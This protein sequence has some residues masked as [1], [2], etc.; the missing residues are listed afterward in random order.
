MN[1]AEL[2]KSF[3]SNISEYFYSMFVNIYKEQSGPNKVVEFKK[4]LKQIK[5]VGFETINKVKQEIVSVVPSYVK[6]VR[7]LFKAHIN[8]I[9]IDRESARK[10]EKA[11]LPEVNVH[12]FIQKLMIEIARSLFNDP[13]LLS[14]C[15]QNKFNKELFHITEKVI[16]EMLPVDDILTV[17][18]DEEDLVFDS[19]VPSRVPGTVKYETGF[20]SKKNIEFESDDNND[21]NND[22]NDDDNYDDNDADDDDVSDEDDN[23]IGNNHNNEV[24]DQVS[25]EEKENKPTSIANEAQSS[26]EVPGPDVNQGHN[27]PNVKTNPDVVEGLKDDN[28]ENKNQIEIEM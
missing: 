17:F 8:S 14:T 15:N 6:F 9:V 28:G 12:V 16:I 1:K 24:G 11:F 20:S 7:I 23:P 18:D 26:K 19:V 27:E 4:E 3:V 5:S 13:H 25:E 22:D 21:D 2:V 10:I